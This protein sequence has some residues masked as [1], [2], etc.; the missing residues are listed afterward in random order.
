MVSYTALFLMPL[1]SEVRQ[2][3]HSGLITK[4]IN[5]G[6]RVIVAAKI[7]D[8][9]LRCQ[10]DPRVQIIPLIQE[11][12]P[13]RFIYLQRILDSSHQIKTRKVGIKCWKYK[14]EKSQGIK[15]KVGNSLIQMF[16]LALTNL[17]RV[18]RILIKQE[19]K[20]EKKMISSKWKA[21]YQKNEVNIVVINIPR[22]DTLHSALATA[23]SINIPRFLYFHTSKDINAN[24]RINHDFTQ[25]GVWNDWMREELIKQNPDIPRSSISIT[26]CGHFDCVGRSDLLLEEQQFR[27]R[28]GVR[29]ESKIILFP[30]SASWVVPEEERYIKLLSDAIQNKRI[31]PSVQIVIR[32]NPMDQTKKWD[33]DFQNNPEIVLVTTDWHWDARQ[34]WCFQRYEDMVFYN[35][36]LYYS[37]VCVSIPSTVTVEC[38]IAN[39]PVI[40]IGFDLSGPKPLPGSIQSFWVADFYQSVVRYGAAKRCDSPDELINAVQDQLM[41]PKGRVSSNDLVQN[42]LGVEPGNAAKKYFLNINNF[43]GH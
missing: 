3:G 5:Q 4:L 16:A 9:D 23:E 24:G 31:Q 38:A 40:N 43:S 8:E 30:A 21:I 28:I 13:R 20:L 12:L 32:P 6:W 35:S 36:L 19:N 41:S 15:Q 42:I 33:I 10:L 25:I 7:V 17:P 34:N 14:K 27:R 26:G 39:L 1:G 37:D 2:F 11:K 22:Q 29:P 18:E